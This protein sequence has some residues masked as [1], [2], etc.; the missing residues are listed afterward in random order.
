MNHLVLARHLGQALY[1]PWERR[2][3]V[4]TPRQ[5]RRVMALIL[6]QVGTPARA[7]KLRGKA[8]GR[9]KGFRLQPLARHPVVRKRPLGGINTS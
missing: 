8:P 3:Q 1:R 7:P 5:V 6:A 2:Q 4:V 9:V